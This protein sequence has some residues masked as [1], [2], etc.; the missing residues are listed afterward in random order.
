MDFDTAGY[1]QVRG[2]LEQDEEHDD[3]SRT[4][5]RFHWEEHPRAFHG[6]LD[7]WQHVDGSVVRLSFSESS[8]EEVFDQWRHQPPFHFGGN[9]WFQRLR[10]KLL[11]V[12]HEQIHH[13]EWG[14]VTLC[15]MSFSMLAITVAAI[16]PSVT[17]IRHIPHAME[18][19]YSNWGIRRHFCLSRCVVR[20]V[21]LPR[22]VLITFCELHK[23]WTASDETQ[24]VLFS[25]TSCRERQSGTWST[26]TNA[27]KRK[28]RKRINWP[29][30]KTPRQCDWWSRKK[31]EMAHATRCNPL[32]VLEWMLSLQCDVRPWPR[33]PACWQ[34]P[35][36]TSIFWINWISHS[37]WWDLLSW[38]R[39]SIQ[40]SFNRDQVVP[41]RTDRGEY[42]SNCR[43]QI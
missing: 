26:P 34:L 20:H 35:P 40:K 24:N 42:K 36:S 10:R 11:Q 6:R 29:K 17:S 21:L 38:K 8:R 13:F 14:C 23:G 2:D 15:L 9:T 19:K 1:E 4:Q 41:N 16:H 28:S 27:R 37:S 3:Q 5:E 12:S 31:K 32:H 18:A 33:N 30:P 39:G 43:F 22:I 7:G 25:S